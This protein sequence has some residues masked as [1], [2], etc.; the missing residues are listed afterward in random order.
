MLRKDFILLPIFVLMCLCFFAF[1]APD[2]SNPLFPVLQGGKWGYIDKLGKIIIP[3]QFKWAH[4]FSDGLA[5]VADGKDKMKFIDKQGRTVLLYKNNET[6]FSDGLAAFSIGEKESYS[7]GFVDKSGRVVINPRF[8][9][10]QKFHHGLA[11]VLERSSK[12]WGFIDKMGNYRIPPRFSMVPPETDP[13]RTHH[14]EDPSWDDAS[15]FT[16]NSMMVSDQM[17]FPESFSEGLEPVQVGGVGGDTGFIDTTGKFV[18]Q[19]QFI[20]ANP[21][22]EGL[23]AVRVRGGDENFGYIDKNGQIVIKPRFHDAYSFSEGLAGVSWWASGHRSNIPNDKKEGYINHS[24]QIVFQVECCM[25]FHFT[26]GLV[27]ST[28][29]NITKWGYRDTTGKWAIPPKFSA[30]HNFDD[31]IAAVEINGKLGYINKTGNYIWKPTK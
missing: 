7:E 5:I 6:E 29:H 24:G 30:A 9:S 18:I 2:D 11:A 20:W 19:P 8:L 12:G 28:A 21:F 13:I 16:Q 31:G 14:Y 10:V 23:A 4:L 26:E 1:S 15:L 22:S 3:P 25:S 17:N 27:P